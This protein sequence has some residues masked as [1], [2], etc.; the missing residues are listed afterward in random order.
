MANY[1]TRSSGAGLPQG[2]TLPLRPMPF[3]SSDKLRLQEPDNYRRCA[4]RIHIVSLCGW[5][6]STVAGLRNDIDAMV[7][8][9]AALAPCACRPRNPYTTSYSS[10]HSS[11]KFGSRYFDDVGGSSTPRRVRTCLLRGGSPHASL[12]P[13]RDSKLLIRW[14]S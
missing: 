12:W 9:T 7:S 14:C 13:S 1:R 10:V 5:P 3:S 4:H 6:T 11:E 2:S 8:R